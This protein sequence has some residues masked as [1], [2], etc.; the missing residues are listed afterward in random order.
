MKKPSKADQLIYKALKTAIEQDKL[1][2]YFDY[3]KLNRPGSMVYNPWESLLPVLIPAFIGL[4]L[5]VTFNIIFGLFFMAIMV[6]AS[7]QYFRK[8]FHHNLIDRTKMLITKSYE[9]LEELWGFGGIVFVN[10][11]DKKQG[12]VSPAGDWKEFVV[13]NFADYMVDKKATPE[14]TPQDE[15]QNEKNPRIS[16]RTRRQ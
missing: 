7:S 11:S 10:A 2:I 9:S 14:N 13:K 3:I 6:F 16:A 12:C 1:R 8:K 5:I 4:L 15:K